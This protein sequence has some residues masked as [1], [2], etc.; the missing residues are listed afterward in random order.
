M[1]FLEELHPSPF[2][3]PFYEVIA[4]LSRGGGKTVTSATGSCYDLCK[5]LSLKH[6]QSYYNLTPSGTKIFIVLFSSVK[7]D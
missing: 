1:K 3:S 2:F 6:P 5:L 4:L 7:D